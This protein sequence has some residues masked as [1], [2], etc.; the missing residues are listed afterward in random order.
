MARDTGFAQVATDQPK[1]PGFKVLTVDGIRSVDEDLAA[2]LACFRLP[3][4]PSQ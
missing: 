1:A 4:I 2:V 3:M